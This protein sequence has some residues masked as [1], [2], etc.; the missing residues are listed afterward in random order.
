M[1]SLLDSIA[2]EMLPLGTQTTPEVGIVHPE[3]EVEGLIRIVTKAKVY[4]IIGECR[5]RPKGYRAVDVGE[6]IEG[7]AVTLRDGKRAM[8]HEPKEQVT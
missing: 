2:T 5:S 3:L 7:V 6:D 8:C 1:V 4:I